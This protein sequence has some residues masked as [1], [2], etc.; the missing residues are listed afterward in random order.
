[1]EDLVLNQTLF[2]AR[3]GSVRFGAVGGG[4]AMGMRMGMRLI[5]SVN[6]DASPYRY[7]G[8]RDA[9]RLEGGAT[10]EM[11]ELGGECGGGVGCMLGYADLVLG[12]LEYA[13]F[14]IGWWG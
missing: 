4:P 12:G 8:M 6:E 11:L 10:S 13:V 7:R 9:V 14:R 5:G 2:G 1:M 3:F